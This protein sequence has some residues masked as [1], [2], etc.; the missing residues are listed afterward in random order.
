MGYIESYLALKYVPNGRV[1][2]VDISRKMVELAEE[3]KKTSGVQNL[4]IFHGRG[5][6]LEIPDHSQ[7]KVLVYANDANEK[8]AH[9]ILREAHRVL[10]KEPESRLVEVY[11]KA[12]GTPDPEPS[13]IER[14]G[15]K[16]V[17]K[18][19]LSKDIKDKNS[20][21]DFW[22]IIARPV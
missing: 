22:M 18:I 6:K 17:N 5:T 10:K 15:F 8:R 2:I 4:D 3:T 7:N 9:Q 11:G 13:K 16:I 1:R 12:P 20:G 19:L 14:A 21:S